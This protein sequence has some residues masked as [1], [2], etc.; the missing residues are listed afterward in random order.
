MAN[1]FKANVGKQVAKADAVK[2]IEKF[3]KERKKD[4]KSV[5]FGR[6]AILAVLS[7][8][9][10]TGISFMFSR[11]YDDGQKKDVDDLVMVGTTEDG[12]LLWND[13]APKPTL[14][15]TGSNTYDFSVTCPPYCPK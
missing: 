15:A 6:E 8:P 4:T 1:E 11:K 3:D 7:L 14:D 9:N 5:F 13:N 10:C 12:T 2:W